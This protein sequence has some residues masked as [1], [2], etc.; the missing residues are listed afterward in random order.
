MQVQNWKRSKSRNLPKFSISRHLLISKKVS[1]SESFVFE[2]KYG[3]WFLAHQW[4]FYCGNISDLLTYFSF[5]TSCLAQK[6]KQNHW[7]LLLSRRDWTQLP[8]IFITIVV[9]IIIIVVI[10]ILIIVT[11]TTVMFLSRGDWAYLLL[12]IITIIVIVLTIVVI[13]III[14]TITSVMLL[15]GGEEGASFSCRQETDKGWLWWWCLQWSWLEDNLLGKYYDDHHLIMMHKHSDCCCCWRGGTLLFFF[16]T[17]S[18][19]TKGDCERTHINNW[20]HDA[21]HSTNTKTK[22]SGTMAKWLCGKEINLYDI[23]S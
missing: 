17:A 12:I 13:V 14:V 23:A 5:E 21:L 10:A 4:L 15:S 3:N 16:S 8:L 9:I 18:P 2:R 11:I 19:R 22:H 6:Q 20:L 1:R 7:L